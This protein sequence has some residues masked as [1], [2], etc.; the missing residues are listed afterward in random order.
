MSQN[1]SRSFSFYFALYSCLFVEL[2]YSSLDQNINDFFNQFNVVANTTDSDFINSQTGVHFLG[3]HG[4]ARAK[5]Y[6]INPIHVQLPSF[7]AGCGGID[8]TLGGLN[9]ASKGEM[10][11]ALKSIASNSIGYAFL[12]GIET[13]SPVISSTMK[14][15]QSWSNQLNAININ[16][17]E[18]GSSLVQGVWPKSQ[19]ASSYICEHA[20]TTNPLFTDHIQA[21]HGCRDD[22]PKR[23]AAVHKVKENNKNILVGSYNIAWEVLRGMGVD[24]EETKNLFMNITGTIVV[25][26]S[27]QESDEKRVIIFP[28]NHEK[29]VEV[30][31]LGGEIKKAYRIDRDE[32]GVKT[33]K[34]IE[35]KPENAWKHKISHTL[36]SIRDKLLNEKPRSESLW[37]EDEKTLI[38]TTHFPIS[39]LI[40]LM[41]QSNGQAGILSID[42][43]SQ[44]IAYER[45]IRFSEDVVKSTLHK[46]E[47]LRAAQVSG[48]E[49]D[50]YIK[51]VQGVLVDLRRLNRLNTEKMLEQQ[52]LISFLLDY[53]RKIREK[54]RGI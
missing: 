12:L 39:S 2:G 40:T 8:Y 21:K 10:K 26:D 42:L 34:A 35:I 36:E 6:D 18:I 9:I 43:Y 16:S 13:V 33:D 19:R 1:L 5:V 20:S 48:Y 38:R 46:A 45:V 50:E 47:S 24:D 23:L 53:D 27:T 22:K 11:Q 14:Q 28:P 44:L 31:T 37:N 41:T 54:D 32:I 15:I 52:N 4:A 25:H 51:K 30:L 17:C 3:G 29:A 49:L 7:S